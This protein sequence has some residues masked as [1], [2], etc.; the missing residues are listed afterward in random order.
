MEKETAR[1]MFKQIGVTTLTYGDLP[2]V[3]GSATNG[4]EV[5][6]V[7]GGAGE[8]FIFR[9]YVDLSGFTIEDLT[10]FV[11]GVD[12]QKG[13]I[14]LKTGAM[15]GLYE[16]DFL[17]TRRMSVAELSN[18][19]GLPGFMG[20]TVDLQEVIYGE[21]MIYGE[22]ANTPG[23]FVQI[24]GEAFG[25]GNPSA[26]DKLHWTRL[27]FFHQAAK[28]DTAVI[29]PTNLVVQAITAE[30][31]DLVYIERLRRSYTQQRQDP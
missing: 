26:A 16:F 6:E 7:G 20:S 21:R 13:L 12:I 23:T 22:N 30:E 28:D 5:I 25:S 31:K 27:I 4:W 3:P 14:P 19:F 18:L 11:Q 9:T 24:S 17:T 2:S 29:Y 10:T 1:Q 15:Q 8:A